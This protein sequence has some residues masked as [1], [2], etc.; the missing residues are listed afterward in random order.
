MYDQGS[1]VLVPFPFTNL[2]SFKKRPAIVV[3]PNWFNYIQED[4]VLIAVTSSI[5]QP[6]NK[7]VEILLSKENVS[8]GAIPRESL[9]KIS[10]IFTCHKD[11]IKKKVAVIKEEKLNEILEKLCLF[12][13]PI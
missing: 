5:S 11:I 2:T 4:I 12:L 9:V 8:E 3:S 1:L 13:Q 7:K 6:M 10:K